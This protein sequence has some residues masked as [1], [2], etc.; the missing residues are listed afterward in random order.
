MFWFFTSVTHAAEVPTLE[1][2]VND[3]AGLLDPA[4]RAELDQRLANYEQ[5]TG[6]Q[7]ALL[8][9]TS[10]QGE[11]LEQFSLRV[12]ES[13]QLGSKQ[14]D[15]GVLLLIVPSERK[16]RIEVGYGLEGA[17]PDALAGKIIRNVLAP[18][19]RKNSY[20]EG[21][22]QAFKHLMHAA[23]GEAVE[24]P[25]RQPGATTDDDGPL[26]FFGAMWLLLLFFF[27]RARRSVGIPF[28]GR[29]H[30]HAGLWGGS[31]GGSSGRGFGG[32]GGFR[33]GGG[34]FGGGGASGGW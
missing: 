15:D 2:R 18:A 11:S 30:R 28:G 12:V 7:F 23:S 4:Q 16:M 31:F 10:L 8:T 6:H 13:W 22:E 33:G 17:I 20:Y 26:A 34:G 9:V 3:I 14:T 32:G 27:W 29:N 25:A 5:G 1:G 19:F 24:V 21:I